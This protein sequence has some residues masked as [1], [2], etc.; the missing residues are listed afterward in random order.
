MREIEFR[1]KRKD[2]KWLY[3]NLIVDR[4]ETPDGSGNMDGG[5]TGLIVTINNPPSILKCYPL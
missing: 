5:K 3:G 2:G 4:F 1:G